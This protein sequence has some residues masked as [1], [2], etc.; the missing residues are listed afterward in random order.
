M[1]W[2]S[3]HLVDYNIAV[4]YNTKQDITV[5]NSAVLLTVCSRVQWNT[6][7]LYNVSEVIAHT[8]QLL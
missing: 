4:W 7:Q 8:A 5:Q 6:G 3:H 2:L 1:K